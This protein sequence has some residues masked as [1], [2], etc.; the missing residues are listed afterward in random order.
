MCSSKLEFHNPPL[1]KLIEIQRK[2]LEADYSC[3]KPEEEFLRSF[4]GAVGSKWPYLAA[5]L[6]FG[7]SEIKEV[8]QEGEGPN[9]AFLM[10]RKWASREGATYGQLYEKL[11][12]TSV[13]ELCK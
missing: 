13:F 10:L 3:V 2:L 1:G 8:K 4:S 11:K 6:S 12:P 9:H 7:G 5:L